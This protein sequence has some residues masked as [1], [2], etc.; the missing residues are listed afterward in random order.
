[1]GRTMSMYMTRRK[2]LMQSMFWCLIEAG[3]GL[4]KAGSR[5]GRVLGQ[6]PI[7]AKSHADPRPYIL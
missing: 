4:R 3:E 2:P 5:V 1:M 7:Q 6:P